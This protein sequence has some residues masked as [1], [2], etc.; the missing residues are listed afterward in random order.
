M[1]GT[2][3]ACTYLQ[4]KT[5]NF[6]PGYP[7]SSRVSRFTGRYILEGYIN[8]NE[9]YAIWDLHSTFRCVNCFKVLSKTTF[10]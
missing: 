2:R 1:F 4:I 7:I 9:I 5:F 10:F 3:I 8:V 6:L